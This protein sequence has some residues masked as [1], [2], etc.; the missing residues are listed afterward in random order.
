MP[1]DQIDDILNGDDWPD[2]SIVG[3][4]RSDFYE[5]SRSHNQ[6]ADTVECGR[7]VTGVDEI[8][9]QAFTSYC[10]LLLQNEQEI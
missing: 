3:N 10:R 5:E 1:S 9:R 2:I 7:M 4:D 6:P 8:S